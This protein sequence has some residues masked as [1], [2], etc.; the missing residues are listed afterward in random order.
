MA[1]IVDLTT[2]ADDHQVLVD[3]DE[4]EERTALLTAVRRIRAL[5]SAP[6][7]VDWADWAEQVRK[8]LEGPEL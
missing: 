8:S 3:L 7:D 6:V 1:R 4:L 2:F 5:A